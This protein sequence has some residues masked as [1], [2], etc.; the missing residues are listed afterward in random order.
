MRIMHVLNNTR[1]FNGMVHVAVDLACVQVRMGH[2]VSIVSAGG[3]FDAL[4]TQYGIR[5]FLIDQKRRPLNLLKAIAAFGRAFGEFE[6]EIVHAH[7][8]TSAGL[9]W[10]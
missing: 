6:P 5:H 10:P 2:S 1:R 8:M 3:D 4:F 7:M 9:A